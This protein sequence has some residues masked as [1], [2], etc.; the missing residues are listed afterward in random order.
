MIIALL[1]Q[2][3]G[4]GKTTLALNLAAAAHLARKRTLLVDLDQQG[5]ALDWY[6][7]RADQPESALSGLSTV[8]LD[9]VVSARQFRELADGYDVVILDGP[10]RL[11]EITRAAAIAADLVVIPVQPGPF[12]LWAGNET[13]ASLDQADNIRAEFDHGPVRRVW[14]VNRASTGTVLARQAPEVLKTAGT[15]A[16]VVVHQRIAFASSA[17]VGESV[18]TTDP[19]SPAAEEIRK[20]YAYLMRRRSRRRAA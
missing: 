8:K 1:N 17:A 5:S 14:V 9:R 10:A 12:D 13:L 15:V 4:V 16:P 2:K 7:A 20:L 19:G 11:G 18:L 6:A 3:G